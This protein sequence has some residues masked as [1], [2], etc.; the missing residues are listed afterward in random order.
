VACQDVAEVIAAILTNLSPHLGKIY[1]LTGPR[2]EDMKAIVAEYSSA[3][4][5]E[6]RYVDAPLEQWRDELRKRN[7][8]EHVYE[9][10]LTMARLHATNRYDRFSRD[11]ETI[12]GRPTLSVREFI[13]RHIERFT[14]D[15]TRT[16]PNNL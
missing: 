7:L 14:T 6:V 15:H 11:V 4:G 10:F 16:S 13:T 2:S 12:T 1:E 3:L 5:R 9:H 8:P